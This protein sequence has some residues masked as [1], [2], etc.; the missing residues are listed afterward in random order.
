MKETP[1]EIK[2][3][4]SG[5]EGIFVILKEIDGQRLC[6][7]SIDG[8]LALSLGRILSGHESYTHQLM[9]SALEQLG[10]KLE[11]IVV[12]DFDD[13]HFYAVLY[14]NDLAG[15]VREIPSRPND[16]ICLAL[17]KKCPMLIND[18]F[19]KINDGLTRLLK[20]LEDKQDPMSNIDWDKIPKS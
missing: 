14:L 7:M 6:Y 16:A 5:P 9:I 19:L 12:A 4:I 10:F 3:P 11:R 1:F 18:D 13:E 2:G 8:I 17:T 20:H 15:S